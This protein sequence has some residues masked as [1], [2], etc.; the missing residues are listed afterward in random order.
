MGE[1]NE[2]LDDRVKGI[3]S[4]MKHALCVTY[5]WRRRN[6]VEK[7]TKKFIVLDQLLFLSS[8]INYF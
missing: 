3:N 6:V 8:I 5:S 4:V 2:K 1:K 7:M